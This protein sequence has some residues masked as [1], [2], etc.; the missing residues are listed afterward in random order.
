MWSKAI[1]GINCGLVPVLVLRHSTA[2]MNM[3]VRKRE[4]NAHFEALGHP[5]ADRYPGSGVSDSPGGENEPL[6][7]VAGAW[8]AQ[9]ADKGALTR[10]TQSAPQAMIAAQAPSNA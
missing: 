8:R 10:L 4:V 2:P 9:V 7:Y 1:G 3:S 6:R 5:R